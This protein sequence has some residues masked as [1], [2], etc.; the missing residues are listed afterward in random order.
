M[1]TPAV[2]RL[3]TDEQVVLEAPGLLAPTEATILVQD[4]PQKRQV[5]HQ[6][7]RQLNATHGMMTTATIKVCHRSR[8][9][10]LQVTT[11]PCS[12]PGRAQ[13]YTRQQR[14]SAG[15]V[16]PGGGWLPSGPQGLSPWGPWGQ[17]SWGPWGRSP[18]G[19]WGRS[20]QGA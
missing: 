18:W 3:E 5:L 13:P 8:V 7:R 12:T 17:L 4:F 19:P 10:S 1:V 9:T 15:L 6:V 16:G 14:I 11:P 2:L 20:P